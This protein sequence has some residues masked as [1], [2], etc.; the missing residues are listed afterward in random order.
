MMAVLGL[1]RLN[2][3]AISVVTIATLKTYGMKKDELFRDKSL[4]YNLALLVEELKNTVK[5]QERKIEELH[6]KL[7]EQS[8]SREDDQKI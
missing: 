7:K 2:I 5:E 6:R 4:F 8:K 1:F 3:N